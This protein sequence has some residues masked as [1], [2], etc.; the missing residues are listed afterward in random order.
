MF[1]FNDDLLRLLIYHSRKNCCSFSR[2]R[3]HAPVTY[4]HID[5]VSFS[6]PGFNS[7]HFLCR[8]G[9]IIIKKSKVCQIIKKVKEDMQEDM[10]SFSCTSIPLFYIYLHMDI[11]VSSIFIR[12][13]KKQKNSNKEPKRMNNETI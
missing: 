6:L 9:I 10:S 7:F 2:K 5:D 13:K 4:I 8:L 3:V 12:T 1:Q 11:H